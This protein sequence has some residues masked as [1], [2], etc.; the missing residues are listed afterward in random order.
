MKKLLTS[1]LPILL[2]LTLCPVFAEAENTVRLSG[3]GR[4]ETSMEVAEELMRV[5]GI[6]HF[7]TVVLATGKNYADALG[8]GYLASKKEAPILLTSDGKYSEVNAFIQKNLKEGGTVYVLGGT[9]AVSEVCLTGLEAF[10]SVFTLFREE[11]TLPAMRVRDR[12]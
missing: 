11:R 9:G 2:V 8:G 7:D 4:Y 5:K 10:N 3:K 6:D 1:L 12:R